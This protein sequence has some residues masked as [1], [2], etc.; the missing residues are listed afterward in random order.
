M[1]SGLPSAV[2]SQSLMREPR[3]STM[4]PASTGLRT[5]LA[6]LLKVSTTPAEISSHL[7]WANNSCCVGKSRSLLV[8][9]C[10]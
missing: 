10:C 6:L 5:S 8:K 3:P 4:F 2:E 1:G 9:T 7:N